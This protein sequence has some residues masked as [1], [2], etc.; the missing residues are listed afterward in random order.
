M[1]M[2]KDYERSIHTSDDYGSLEDE[3]KEG[4]EVE[5]IEVVPKTEGFIFHI[6]RLVKVYHLI[7]EITP[8][9][10]KLNLDLTFN[11]PKWKVDKKAVDVY[12]DLPDLQDMAKADLMKRGLF[13]EEDD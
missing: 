3:I 7:R 6:T 8:V 11:V 2:K 12:S 13:K 9:K 10:I 5:S 1:K 4:W